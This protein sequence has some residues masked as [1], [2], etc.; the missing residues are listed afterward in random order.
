MPSVG[1]DAVPVDPATAQ[2]ERW[3]AEARAA[4]KIRREYLQALP[5]APPDDAEAEEE[6]PP[7]V[8]E[9]PLYPPAPVDAAAPE[10]QVPE[11]PA[12]QVRRENL[13]RGFYKQ[14]IEHLTKYP[15]KADDLAAAGERLDDLYQRLEHEKEQAQKAAREAFRNSP[16][17]VELATALQELATAEARLQETVARQTPA[18]DELRR[19]M[20]E[21]GDIEAAANRAAALERAV[22]LALLLRAEA[23]KRLRAARLAAGPAWLEAKAEAKR[24]RS[25]LAF[26]YVARFAAKVQKQI[27]K[28]MPRLALELRVREALAPRGGDPANDPG[29]V[30]EAEAALDHDEPDVEGQA[31]G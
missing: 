28:D 25:A 21:G 12:E 6:W 31:D 22:K 3:L 19:V 16:A 17:G 9:G 11:R 13:A 10:R 1:A 2:R 7:T 23:Q 27:L 26:A 29:A 14:V 20:V 4:G 8:V 15:A 5:P 30:A 18:S 24:A